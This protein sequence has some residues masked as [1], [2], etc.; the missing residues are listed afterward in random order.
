MV[1]AINIDE[2]VTGVLISTADAGGGCSASGAEPAKQS[3][4]G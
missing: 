1:I 2:V 4:S 3:D